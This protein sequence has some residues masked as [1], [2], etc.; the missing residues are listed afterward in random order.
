[1]L[2]NGAVGLQMRE[3]K[4]QGYLHFLIAWRYDLV[5]LDL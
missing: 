4:V 5:P 3:C 2:A 1:M